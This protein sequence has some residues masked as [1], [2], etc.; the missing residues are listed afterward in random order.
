MDLEGSLKGITLS[1][2][3]EYPPDAG[4]CHL[5]R[6]FLPSETSIRAKK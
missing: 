3:P 5:K 4:G 2:K 6:A 1:L